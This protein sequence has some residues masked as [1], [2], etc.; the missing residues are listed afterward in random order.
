MAKKRHFADDLDQGDNDP[1]SDGKNMNHYG[2]L[3]DKW[4]DIQEEYLKK[5][6]ELETEDLYFEGGGFEGLLEK[7]SRLRE[8]SVDDIRTEIRRW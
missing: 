5:Y 3:P 6:P 1:E 7:I 4:N 8:K 2:A